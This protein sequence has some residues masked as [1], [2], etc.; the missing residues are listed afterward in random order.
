MGTTSIS[1]KHLDW[2]N[3]VYNWV[4]IRDSIEGESSIKI[5]NELYLPMPAA[6]L[7]DSA[8]APSSTGTGGSSTG[9]EKRDIHNQL[10]GSLNPNY[11]TNAAYSAYKSR[12][13]FPEYP[14][15]IQRGLVGIAVSNAPS[16]ELPSELEYL[17][18]RFT[19]SG[20]SLVEFYQYAIRE[21]LTMGRLGLLA[22]VDDSPS[23]GGKPVAVSYVAE[24]IY[25]WNEKGSQTS[26]DFSRVVLENQEDDD[27]KERVM[28]L[29][30]S[31]GA[32][33]SQKFIDNIPVGEAVEVEYMGKLINAIPFVTLGSTDIT[34]DV[35]VAPLAGV[36]RSAIQVYQMDADLRQAEYMSCN[37]TL[38]VT[39]ITEEF[40]PDALGSTLAII[41][42][43]PDAKAFYPATDTSALAH[44]SG[45]I[46]KIELG[47]MEQ[48]ASLLGSGA[49][50]SGEALRIR[51][52]SN[53]ATLVSIAKSV[54]KGI[55]KI[56]KYIGQFHGLDQ[57]KIDEIKFV[58]NVEFIT[59]LLSP[60]QQKEL[61]AS[62]MSGAM[63][64]KTLLYN[65]ERA[66]LLQESETAEDELERIDTEGPKDGEIN[67]DIE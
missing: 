26:T 38:F 9:V 1:E 22:D 24:S 44:V 2:N 67:I 25:N 15:H 34:P 5:Q 30:L 21:V 65:F 42:P 13:K 33:A 28:E 62:W 17:N 39:G 41:L 64:K 35:D 36:C 11:H 7:L 23:G 12:A 57:K 61:V 31:N 63:S 58:P 59:A 20:S 16:I 3:N 46:D 55:E 49:N 27:E 43:P 51:Q 40:K 50:A 54:G 45:R 66:G 53:T 32:Y 52:S 56:I 19:K 6:M 48:G 10:T 8:K 37:P 47:A 14:S 18:E 60:A 4:L 29:T